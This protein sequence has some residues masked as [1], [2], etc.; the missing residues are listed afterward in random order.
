M[1]AWIS[2]HEWQREARQEARAAV[3]VGAPEP[4]KSKIKITVL[5]RSCIKIQRADLDGT[6][7]TIDAYAPPGCDKDYNPGYAEWHWQQL[8]PN[9]V[10][11]HSGYS[12][13]ASISGGEKAE[14]VFSGIYEGLT[15]D[16]RVAELQ[17]WISR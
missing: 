17:V 10:I 1:G 4:V 12:N 9:G 7:L 2:F 13:R 11:L 8:S 16:D 15:D 6:S 5:N 3:Y 14:F